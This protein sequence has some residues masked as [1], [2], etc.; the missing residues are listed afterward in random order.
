MSVQWYTHPDPRAAA[1]AC[2]RHISALLEEALA[3]QE[4]ATL[5]VSGGTTPKLLFQELVAAGFRFSRVHLFWVDERCVPPQ[6]QE[7]NYHL[8]EDYL[9]LPARIPGAQLHRIHGE[10]NPETAALKY[11]EDIRNF[12]G[13]EDAEQPHFD[14]VQCGIGL[15]GHTASLFPGEPAI[16][17]RDHIAAAL[18]AKHLGK[19]RISLL[20]GALLAARNTVFLAAGSDK[21]PAVGQ[22]FNGEFDPKQFPAQ[23]ISRKGRHAAW[24]LDQ[25]AASEIA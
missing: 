10:I 21:A 9:I 19:W 18:Y 1:V 5:A 15:D 6:D 13:L 24:F 23:L 8:A 7:S 22:V 16:D 17:D 2:A 14:V 20:P 25:A 4:H 11:T 3:S 12:F